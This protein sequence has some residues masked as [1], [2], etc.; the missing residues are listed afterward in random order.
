MGELTSCLFCATVIVRNV[1][2]EAERVYNVSLTGGVSHGG[3]SGVVEKRNHENDQR[4][5]IP[6]G[7]RWDHRGLRPIYRTSRRTYATDRDNWRLFSRSSQ[8]CPRSSRYRRSECRLSVGRVII[9]SLRVHSL[10]PRPR[11]RETVRASS[12]RE[13]VGCICLPSSASL[14]SP[15]D[16]FG[17][18]RLGD[19]R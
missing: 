17:S 3:I 2:A 13:I 8:L 9:A 10:Q 4:N 7:P 16:G 14:R 5:E 12:V 15:Y 19:S 1:A 18:T 11:V 6:L